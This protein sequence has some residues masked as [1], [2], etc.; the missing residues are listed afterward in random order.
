ML[1]IKC[2]IDHLQKPLDT[3]VVRSSRP[4]I[5][6]TFACTD[7][8]AYTQ[9]FIAL[10]IQMIVPLTAGCWYTLL[11]DCSLCCVCVSSFI[12]H[13]GYTWYTLANEMVTC[14]FL[15][16]NATIVLCLCV[17]PTVCHPPWS[18]QYRHGQGRPINA[19]QCKTRMLD[20]WC[21]WSDLVVNIHHR[22]WGAACADVRTISITDMVVTS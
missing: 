13:I 19:T 3:N 11:T 15:L 18:P 17:R 2:N 10:L 7:L 22:F 8:T 16:D 6:K 20:G 21:P 14:R 4:N 9:T 1:Y 5:D 12:S